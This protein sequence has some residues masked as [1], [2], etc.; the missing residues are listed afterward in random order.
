[1]LSYAVHNATREENGFSYLGLAFK[2]KRAFLCVVD[3][4]VRV[5]WTPDTFPA[6]PRLGS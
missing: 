5:I 3:S 2:E 1:M 4:D 6:K